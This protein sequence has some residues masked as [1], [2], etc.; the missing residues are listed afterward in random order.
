[1][2]RLALALISFLLMAIMGAA[3]TSVAAEWRPV[4]S[5]PTHQRATSVLASG[6]LKT[7]NYLVTADRTIRATKTRSTKGNVDSNVSC[8]LQ[9]T[10]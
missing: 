6:S 8:P 2:T 10:R 5:S 3:S 7:V 4:P 9:A 1:M